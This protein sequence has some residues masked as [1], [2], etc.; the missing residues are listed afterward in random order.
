[1]QLT[2]WPRCV[3][4]W[5]PALSQCLR[6]VV[7]SIFHMLVSRTTTNMPRRAQLQLRLQDCSTGR[8][9]GEG[10]AKNC[11]S[12]CMAAQQSWPGRHVR[13]EKL[14]CSM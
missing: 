13:L 5:Q 8:G 11:Y 7:Q 14:P 12:L 9:G 1:M 2:I 4:M 10:G 6:R 3:E